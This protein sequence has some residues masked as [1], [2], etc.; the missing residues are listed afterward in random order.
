MQGLGL[1]GRFWRPP[2]GQKKTPRNIHMV[3]TRNM[4]CNDRNAQEETS[5]PDPMALILK[6][7]KEMELL[8][9]K[10]KEEIRGIK[11]RSE[12]E[13]KTLRKENAPMKQKL[14]EKPNILEAVDDIPLGDNANT[15]IHEVESSYQENIRPASTNA[16]GTTP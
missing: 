16:L 6:M 7:Q 8:K 12:E 5:H 2:W 14:A 13:M 4:I 1:A 9:K 3:T 15:N 11:R 10:S